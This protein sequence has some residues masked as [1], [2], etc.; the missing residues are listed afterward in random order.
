VKYKPMERSLFLFVWSFLARLVH[1]QIC[2]SILDGTA[3]DQKLILVNP[4]A[5]VVDYLYYLPAGVTKEKLERD[6]KALLDKLTLR[7]L[8]ATCQASIIELTCASVYMKCQPGVDLSDPDTFNTAI[9]ANLPLPFTRP[10][11]SV[12]TSVISECGLGLAPI[13]T[14]L[15]NCT[16]TFDYTFGAVP[17]LKRA[18]TRYDSNTLTCYSPKKTSVAFGSEPYLGAT[19]GVCRG[20]V[21]QVFSAAGSAIDPALAVMQQPFVVQSLIEGILQARVAQLPEWMEPACRASLRKWGCSSADQIPGQVTWRPA[22]RDTK[23]AT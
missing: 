23:Y 5:R 19:T 7:I 20:L 2:T 4:C 3:L 12:C 10:C 15:P 1:S 18:A 21:Q 13:L 6:A 11:S 16:A 8:S 14:T 22:V 9:Y 17:A